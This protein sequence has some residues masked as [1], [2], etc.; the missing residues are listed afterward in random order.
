MDHPPSA[1][2]SAFSARSFLCFHYEWKFSRS[3]FIQDIPGEKI[4]TITNTSAAAARNCPAWKLLLDASLPRRK[5]KKK[6][7][8]FF[9]AYSPPSPRLPT[10]FRSPLR[11]FIDLP[12]SNCRWTLGG[13]ETCLVLKTSFGKVVSKPR[14]RFHVYLC[15][16]WVGWLKIYGSY[17]WKNVDTC[18]R[19]GVQFPNVPSLQAFLRNWRGDLKV[20]MSVKWIAEDVLEI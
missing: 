17:R 2:P 5:K 16:L 8:A 13:I 7:K 3:C 14:C 19:R 18:Y 20:G 15:Y 6:G 9:H 1:L 10:N 4:A 11:N 12:F